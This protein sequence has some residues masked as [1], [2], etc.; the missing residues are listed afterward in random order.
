M[1]TIETKAKTLYALGATNL[2]RVVHYRL[3]NKFSRHNPQIK[4]PSGTFFFEVRASESPLVPNKNWLQEAAYFGN[5]LVPISDNAPDWHLNPF[6]GARM[7]ETKPWWKIS[8]FATHCGDIKV[9]WEASRFDWVLS[10]SQ[11]A[12]LGDRNSL[13]KLNEWLNNWCLNNPPFFGVNW[14]CGQEAA[15][16]VMHLAIATLIVD[17]IQQASKSLIALI[18]LHLQRIASTLN[19][20]IAQDNNHGTSEAAALFIGGSWLEML[21]ISKGKKWSRLGRKWLENRISYLIEE[22]GSFSQYSVNYH[23]VLI[24]TLCMV[25]VWRRKLSLSA[26]SD[27]W[28]RKCSAATYWLFHMV[29]DQT[30]DAPNIGA[31]DGARLLQLTDSDYRDYR[32]SVQL[33]MILFN[34]Q[35]AYTKDGNW[36]YPLQWLQIAIPDNKAEPLKS[37][38][39]NDGGFAILKRRSVFLL[40]RYPRFRFRPSHADALHIDLWVNCVNLLRDAGTYSYNTSDKWLNYFP[41]TASHNT[42]QFDQRDQMPRLS[43]FLFGNWL[44][45]SSFTQITETELCSTFKVS[46]CDSFGVTHQRAVELYN[47]YLKVNDTINGFKKSAVIRWRLVPGDW[48]L[49]DH[50]LSNQT[51]FIKINTSIPIKRFELVE[52][53]ESRYYQQKAKLPVLEIEVDQPGVVEMEYN[54]Y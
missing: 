54:W 48:K 1:R 53:W 3:L 40:M 24:D 38:L 25:E 22:D 30:G 27:E 26:F 18:H 17:Q 47:N 42:I 4:V 10:F 37:K 15:I 46:Y 29:D 36:N 51:H 11:Q 16:R 6:T 14:K 34:H 45:T 7:D 50:S 23:R 9:I 33:A 41:G 43:R 19:Y 44:K 31:N 52:G 39:F 2:L 12:K 32:P 49:Q 8:D 20:A 5:Q 13:K 35:Q 28:R 21:G